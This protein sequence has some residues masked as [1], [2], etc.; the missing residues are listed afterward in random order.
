MLKNAIV[1]KSVRC[2]LAAGAG[3]LIGSFAFAAS[4][5]E[6]D[7]AKAKAEGKLVWYTS[8]AIGQAN[9]LALMFEKQTGIKVELFRSGGSAILRR[10]MQEASA[11]KIAADVMTMSDPA[12]ADQLSE[13][14][15]FVA[16]KPKDF[17]K[18]TETARNKDGYWIAQRLNAIT[19]YMRGDKVPPA[20]RPKKWTDLTDAKYDGK[21]V[22][23]DP[24]FTSVQLTTVGVLA[25]KYGWDYYEKLND[26]DIMIVQGNQQVADNIKRGERLIAVGA[27]DVY[28][29]A[30]RR[31]GH[32]FVSI[33]PEDGTLLI[34]SPTG[35]IKGG[36][37][38]NAAKAFAEFMISPEAQKTFPET[39]EYSAR[40]D[41]APPAG[42][43]KVD[44]IKLMP[45]DYE[46]LETQA[47]E[48]KEKFNDIF[49]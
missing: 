26:G 22:M 46:K 11:G 47:A 15:T 17:D 48:I 8:T 37:H 13:K 38:P 28:I 44:E 10:F 16:F 7:M 6:V 42:N 35:I 25:D 9:N 41:M 43:P 31:N 27:L 14:G 2:W 1:H 19:I 36:P 18:I 45:V 30:D 23:T 39:G 5:E 40:V 12:A 21:L 29:A 33:Y 20:D 24:S 3:L 49:R 4:A 32:D 34:P